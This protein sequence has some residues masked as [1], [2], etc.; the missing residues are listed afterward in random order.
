[1]PDHFQLLAL[2]SMHIGPKKLQV[3]ETSLAT[4]EVTHERRQSSV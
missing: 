2:L 1:M 4:C 3:L